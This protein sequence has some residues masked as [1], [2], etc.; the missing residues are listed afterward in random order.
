MAE[1]RAT[2]FIVLSAAELEAILRDDRILRRV[3]SKLTLINFDQQGPLKI[4]TVG[5]SCPLFQSL[6][7]C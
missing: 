3:Q 7:Y 1:Q 6:I 4:K 2:L 5:P